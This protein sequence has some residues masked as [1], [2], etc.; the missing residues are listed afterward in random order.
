MS[1]MLAN[2]YIPARCDTSSCVSHHCPSSVACW[3]FRKETC[4]RQVFTAF[5]V[6][7]GDDRCASF[8][9]INEADWVDGPAPDP[10]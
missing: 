3:R 7:A 6:P 8:V 4:A 2:R 9:A 1:L 10:Y 5:A